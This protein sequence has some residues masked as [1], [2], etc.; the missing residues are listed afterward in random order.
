MPAGIG[1][2]LI[3]ALA[4]VALLLAAVLVAL[5]YPTR[6]GKAPD[7]G[8]GVTAEAVANARGNERNEVVSAFDGA[9][10]LLLTGRPAVVLI[11]GASGSG[12]TTMSGKLAHRLVNRGRLVAVTAMGGAGVGG[13]ATLASLAERA[14]AEIISGRE[15]TDPAVRAYEAVDEARARRFDVLIVD[16][17]DMSP[18]DRS[19]DELIR[20]SRVLE[21]A[22]GRVDEVLLV[23]DATSSETLPYW[24]AV[25]DAVGVTGVALSKVDRA[26][27]AGVVHA[28]LQRLAIPVKLVGTGADLGDLRAFDP[29]WFST[30]VEAKRRGESIP[31]SPRLAS[32]P[33]PFAAES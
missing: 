5:L 16:T 8:L 20:M 33:P 25:D 11:V 7:E 24:R 15:P 22:A 17:G 2:E 28:A 31:G 13:E 3:T 23:V 19:M 32:E 30:I 9:A 21:R 26:E 10:S 27:E 14:G 6:E 12:R 29:V 18:S 4:L 1:F